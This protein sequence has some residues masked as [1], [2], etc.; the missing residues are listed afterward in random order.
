MLK[1]NT[2][3][4]AGYAN[5]SQGRMIGIVH[6]D[7][8]YI[9]P[10]GSPGEMIMIPPP[11]FIIME[12]HHKGKE[13]K[14]SIFPC[15]KQ[16]AVLE[17]KRDGKK[18]VYR[19][20]SNMV[21]L[22][23]ALTIHETQ[24]QTL[25]RIILLLGR[26]PGF[27]VG[28][29]TWSLLYVA[30]SRTRKLSNI[31]FFPTG[32]TKYYH[33]MYFAHLMR[34][35]MP[36][37]LKRWHRSY[38][39]HSWDRNI[40]RNEHL[41]KVRKAEKR[42]KRLGELKTKRLGW[43]ELQSL[44]KQMGYKATTRDN[45]MNLFCKLKEHMV[46]QMV[47][48]PSKDVKP[49]ERKEDRRRKRAYQKMEA[50]SSQECKSSSRPSKRLRRRR[51]SKHDDELVRRKSYR[52]RSSCKRNSIYSDLTSTTPLRTVDPQGVQGKPP[53]K[54][55]RKSKE[56][57]LMP[58]P[59]HAEHSSVKGLDNLGQTCYFNCIVQCLFH[60]P[61]FRDAIENVS[62]SARSFPVLRELQRLFTR[63]ARPTSSTHLSPSRYFS[64]AMKISECESAGMNKNRQE[65]ASA[66]F[67]MLVE[68]L[69]LKL[70][71][72]SELFEGELL[73]KLTCQR[74][75]HSVA[76]S[77]PFKFLAISL[78]LDSNE[79]YSYALPGTHDIYDLLDGFVRPE[80]IT[81]YNCTNCGVQDITEKK[82]DILSTPQILVLGLK[83]F[84][85]I[86]KLNDFV[87]FPLELSL[88]Y[89]NVDNE[90]YQLY[91]IAGVV[92]HKGPSIA[93][94]HYISY[95]YSEGIWFEINDSSV[96]EVEWEIVRNLRVYLLFYLRL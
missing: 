77:V 92:V 14:T 23:F 60:C 3:P 69:R 61:L 36:E 15:E 93:A 41:Q 22:T 30:L 45:K 46:K 4:A 49:S 27:N 55:H 21:V 72:L 32:S 90:Q 62:Q 28:K 19:C 88:E 42:L 10:S 13:K 95:V 65:D 6:D 66:F 24:G 51:Q 64:A 73:S 5:G 44:V 9:L 31:R 53:P 63:M 67:M 94:G 71:P 8:D 78:P 26:L 89:V 39:N 76:M 54:K 7:S 56:K 83:R 38:V 58:P 74:C 50:K 33:S 11:R 85:G 43:V 57:I 59:I 1:T 48:K 12:V 35:S 70:K 17:Y 25:P 68:H 52:N 40:L 91:Q 47:W 84:K 82:L 20:W 75:S 86:R 16:Q 29:I 18:F 79:Q 87:Q 96:R 2:F 37:N 81:G 80:F 34:L